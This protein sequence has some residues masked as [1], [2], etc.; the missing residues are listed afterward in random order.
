MRIALLAAALALVLAAAGAA[1][2]AAD[3]PIA[4]TTLFQ[5][6][7]AD[8]HPDFSLERHA[9]ALIDATPRGARISFAFRD[10]NRD[11]VADALIRAHDRGVIVDGVIDGGERF[12]LVVQRLQAALGADHFVICG[13]PAFEFNSCIANSITPSLQHNKFLVFSK[14]A[15]GREPVVLET[16]ENFL[17]PTQFNYY[18]DMVEIDGD[19]ALYE[20]YVQYVADMKAQ[21]RSD[22]H[23]LTPKGDDGRNQIFLAPRRQASF[24]ADDTIVDEM[25]DIDCSQG[26]SATGH[27]LVRIANMAFRTER[28]VIMR[29][30]ID[31]HDAGCEIDVIVSNADGDILAGLVSAGIPVHPFFLRSTTTRPQVVVHDKFWIVD[32]GSK[33]AGARRKTVYA[34]SSNWR[35]DEQY[36]DDLLLKIIDD[37]VYADFDRYWELIRSRA[38]SDQTRRTELVAPSSAMR[39][40]PAPNAEGWNRSPVIV[41]LAASD[42]HNV[43]AGGL[44]RLHVD[45]SGAQNG[46][47]D[48]LSEHDGYSVQELPISAE[49][50]TTVTYFAEDVNGNRETPHT[51]TVR[52]DRAPPVLSGLPKGCEIWPP[53][54]RMVHV[55]DVVAADDPGSGVSDLTVSASSDDADDDGDVRIDGG[56]VDVRAEKAA[57]GQTRTYV[58]TAVATDLAGNRTEASGTCVV[59]R[60]PTS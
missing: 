1:P 24:D 23:F 10:F 36:S 37:G 17:E 38:A 19:R 42:G 33:S 34:G 35:P 59:P 54:G 55:A 27:G 21:V 47:W 22:D 18:N 32:A 25:D 7:G 50:E 46:S 8:P 41:R 48:F 30:L 58:I 12:R 52:I 29:E 5:D 13:S 26:G 11:P 40:T 20:A 44:K 4:Y 14:L 57:R 9:I 43:G 31:L 6:P 45:M 60:S 53:N 51:A 49:G 28:A 2:A 15:D 56:S 3:S 39:V 16:S